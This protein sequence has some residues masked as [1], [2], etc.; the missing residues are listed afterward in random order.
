[1]LN[2]GF[3]SV[4]ISMIS[5]NI[6]IVFLAIIFRH[7]S[8][9]LRTGYKLLSF[10]SILIAIRL[11]FP[12]ELPIST[13]ILLPELISRGIMF[14]CHSRFDVF[15]RRFSIWNI[16]EIIWIVGF[17]YV[18]FRYIRISY[19]FYRFIQNYGRDITREEPYHTLLEK[20]C[21]K[22]KMIKNIHIIR[23]PAVETPRVCR[24]ISYYILIPDSLKL[25]DTELYFILRHE[26]S[27]IFHHDLSIKSLI[28]L[29]CLIYWWNPFCYL[30][31]KKADLLCELRVDKA[32]VLSDPSTKVTYLKC[33]LEVASQAV[34]N[35]PMQNY[36]GI[37]FSSDS[38]SLLSRRFDLLIKDD[39]VKQKKYMRFLLVPIC[40]VYCFSYLYI[41][42]AHYA[43]PEIIESMT[44]VSSENTYMVLNP[45]G[46]YTVY[47]QEGV[48]EIVDSLDYYP[49]DCKIYLSQEEAIQ[50]EKK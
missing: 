48:S 33:L 40:I 41:F 13:N 23:I 49:K 30:L 22:K 26:I 2:F 34:E 16:M 24:F 46:T 38:K 11:F 42:E 3:S 9:M 28:E 29:I 36:P 21:S 18:F 50:N 1:M 6:L 35:D 39:S 5:C 25:S 19:L 12:F 45:D 27:H 37:S 17:L 7:Q 43:P 31:K 4:L 20:T 14:L 8:L 44:I 47:Y 10:F 15:G 32:V